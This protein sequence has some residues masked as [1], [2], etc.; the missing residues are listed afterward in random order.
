MSNQFF[1]VFKAALHLEALYLQSKLLK[2]ESDHT[3]G[4]RPL[5]QETQQ[6]YL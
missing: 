3:S 4:E 1:L 6:T 5:E 2:P